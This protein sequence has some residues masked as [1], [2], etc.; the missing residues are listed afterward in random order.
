MI[1]TYSNRFG[2]TR[3]FS[4]RARVRPV[5]AVIIGLL[6]GLEIESRVGMQANQRE[7]K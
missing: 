4:A 3:R 6:Y 7:R 5:F 2:R 1:P